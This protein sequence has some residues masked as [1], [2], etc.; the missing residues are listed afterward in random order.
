MK[1]QYDDSIIKIIC[2]SKDDYITQKTEYQSV[3]EKSEQN[4]EYRKHQQ[5]IRELEVDEMLND[6]I[7]KKPMRFLAKKYGKDFMK[8]HRA[9]REFASI[10]VLEETKNHALANSVASCHYYNTYNENDLDFCIEELNELMNHKEKLN[11]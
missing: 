8:N 3:R 11:D 7:N 4:I 5:E 1:Y 2:G 6:I 10:V 9:Y